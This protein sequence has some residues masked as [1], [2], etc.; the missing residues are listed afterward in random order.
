MTT[1]H[2]VWDPDLVT[3]LP[4]D[5]PKRKPM[6]SQQ[7]ENDMLESGQDDPA[8]TSPAVSARQPPSP[9]IPAP[10]TKIHTVAAQLPRRRNR[11]IHLPKV[12]KWQLSSPGNLRLRRQPQILHQQPGRPRRPAV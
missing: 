4:G 7:A 5:P 12:P 8:L 9:S 6:P 11:Q 10:W 1:S 3:W 2:R